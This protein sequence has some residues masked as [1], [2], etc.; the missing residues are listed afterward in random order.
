MSYYGSPNN[1]GQG[2]PSQQRGFQQQPPNGQQQYPSQFP[3]Q[4]Q[5]PQYN[6]A[7]PSTFSSDDQWYS[8]DNPESPKTDSNPY[9]GNMNTGYSS[10]VYG[11]G[12]NNMSMG[13]GGE[14]DYDNEPPILE[15]L[16][17][18]FDHIWSKTQAVIHP[19]KVL[20]KRSK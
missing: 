18:R 15:E 9:N 1:Y 8:T 3:N 14:E 20:F 2:N 19:L 4:P 12:I 16:G 11:G 6:Q 10:S 17:I 13:V 5:Q 7:Y